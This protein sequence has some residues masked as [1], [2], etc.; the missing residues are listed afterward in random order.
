M[1]VYNDAGF[2][3]QAVQSIL[4]QTEPRF[5]FLIMNDGSTDGTGDILDRFAAADSRIKVLHQENRGTIPSVNTLYDMVSTPLIARMDGDDVAL[6]HRFASQLAFMETQPDIAV[7]GSN[8]HDMNEKGVVTEYSAEYPLD[9]TTIAQA[10]KTRNVICQPSVMMRTDAVRAVGGYRPMYRHCEDYDLWLRLSERFA[11]AN[12]ADKLM[13]YRRS[14]G[15]VSEKNRFTQA[16]GSVLAQIAHAERVAGRPD[17]FEGR[18]TYPDLIELED[19]LPHP[20]MMGGIRQR[21]IDSVKYSA[22]GLQDGGIALMKAQL[23]E[24]GQKADYWR[25]AGRMVKLGMIPQA[26]S[27]SVALLRA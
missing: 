20:S 10:L 19:M 13:F 1:S 25:T 11:L 9:P 5:E 27:L 23:R 16:F 26:I 22:T 2:V 8:T 18:C 15:Q 6:P 4:D 24:T 12:I 17:P 21:V 3:A 14:S 7:V